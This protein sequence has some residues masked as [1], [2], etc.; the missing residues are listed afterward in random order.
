MCSNVLS[1][2]RAH[3]RGKKTHVRFVVVLEEVEE[4]CARRQAGRVKDTLP[5]RGNGLEVGHLAEGGLHLKRERQ[6]P[7]RGTAHC[8]HGG[9]HARVASSCLRG[10]DHLGQHHRRRAYVPHK[11]LDECEERVRLRA[12]VV[13][14]ARHFGPVRHRVGPLAENARIKLLSQQP[15]EGAEDGRVVEVQV[16]L[17]RVEG[18]VKRDRPPADIHPQA[19]RAVH[20]GKHT[21]P[22]RDGAVRVPVATQDVPSAIVFA[23]LFP[24]V[25]RD[26]VVNVL[27]RPAEGG[28]KPRVFG[29]RVVKH[30]IG[31]DAEARSHGGGHEARPGGLPPQSWVHRIVNHVIPAVAARRHIMRQQQQVPEAEV[32]PV[33]QRANEVVI[34]ARRARLAVIPWHPK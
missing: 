4:G 24:P 27:S 19:V 30:C 10:A 32:R 15:E 2:P 16:H 21:H 8:A 33:G 9:G 31:G 23:H 28:L 13:R 29:A 22:L 17:K 5:K 3:V 14:A 18:A 12:P 7:L 1:Q 11:R 20:V 26:V 25:A 34:S 6:V